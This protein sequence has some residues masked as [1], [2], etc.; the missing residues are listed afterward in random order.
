MICD[1]YPDDGE[2]YRQFLCRTWKPSLPVAHLNCLNPSTAGRL[3]DDP[4]VRHAIA[5]LDWLGY[6]TMLLTNAFDARSTDPKGLLSMPVPVS[7][8]NDGWI[9]DCVNC[10]DIT[11]MGFGSQP[12]LSWRFTQVRRLLADVDLYCFA[13]NADGSP[14]HPLYVRT[15]TTPIL[16]RS[17]GQL[18][19]EATA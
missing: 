17:G 16:W 10:A 15:E 9:T 2:P 3:I 11:I 18:A 5:I 8:E 1:S 19:L 14:K 6:G 4:T 7:P 12:K 13:K